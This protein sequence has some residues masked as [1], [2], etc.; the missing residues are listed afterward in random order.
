MPAVLKVA[1]PHLQPGEAKLA[2]RLAKAS[3]IP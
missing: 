1:T 3:D 2:M